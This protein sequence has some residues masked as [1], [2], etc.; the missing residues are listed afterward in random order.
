LDTLPEIDAECLTPLG[1]PYFYSVISMDNVGDAIYF[2]G[3][4]ICIC[5]GRL[6]WCPM[7]GKGGRIL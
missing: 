1:K 7:D 3:D 2:R 6:H 4:A 5:V